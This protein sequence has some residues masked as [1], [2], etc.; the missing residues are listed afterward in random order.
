MSSDLEEGSATFLVHDSSLQSPEA[1]FYQWL[2]DY[3]FSKWNRK[4]YYGE[5]RVWINVNSHIFAPGLPGVRLAQ[6]IGA[7]PITIEDFKTIY[8]ILEQRKGER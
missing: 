4:G 3:G 7:C 6:E 8:G 5:P 1:P 2:H